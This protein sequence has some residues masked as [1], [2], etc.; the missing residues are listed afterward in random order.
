[1]FTVSIT[2]VENNFISVFNKVQRSLSVCYFYY[3]Y[4][5]IIISRITHKVTDGFG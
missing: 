5:I 3:Y 4:N 2:F 1:M